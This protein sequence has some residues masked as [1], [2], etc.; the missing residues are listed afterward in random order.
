MKA[1]LSKYKVQRLSQGSEVMIV[2]SGGFRKM[3]KA[4]L[5]K[6]ARTSNRCLQKSFDIEI[7]S[8]EFLVYLMSSIIVL[9][10]L[11]LSSSIETKVA[12]AYECIPKGQYEDFQKL[13]IWKGITDIRLIIDLFRTRLIEW[14]SEIYRLQIRITQ[15]AI[16]S[17]INILVL[18][19]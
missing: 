16:F 1:Q 12:K 17:L 2:T 10:N 7:G 8:C 18:R 5:D 14:I 9:F 6:G 4:S 19:C 11:K 3:L 15:S 13:K